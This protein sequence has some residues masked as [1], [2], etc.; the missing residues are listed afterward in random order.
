MSSES[1]EEKQVLSSP[2]VDNLSPRSPRIVNGGIVK[3]RSASDVPIST[4]SSS[5]KKIELTVDTTTKQS[6]PPASN[7]AVKTP[8]EPNTTVNRYADKSSTIFSHRQYLPICICAFLLYMVM[9]LLLG[10]DH[11]FSA[12]PICPLGIPRARW[13]RDVNIFTSGGLAMAIILQI[14]RIY[15]SIFREENSLGTL[16][17]FYSSTCVNLIACISHFSIVWGD[18]GGQCQ[19]V[20]G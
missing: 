3:V 4:E 13:T 2:K 20:W 11:L 5:S 9:H 18:W 10:L 16:S 12:H 14:N 6:K 1:K 17:S 7:T 8:A 15:L 19:D